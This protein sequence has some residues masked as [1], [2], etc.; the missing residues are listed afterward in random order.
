MFE[1]KEL[2]DVKEASMWATN[3]IGKTVTP[4]NIAYLINYGRVKKRGEN[5]N[6]FVAKKDLADYYK[7]CARCE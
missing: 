2:L 1:A 5:G 6:I 3:H 7:S 4:S